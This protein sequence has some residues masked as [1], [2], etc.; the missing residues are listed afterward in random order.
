MKQNKYYILL[1]IFIFS[2][3]CN[4]DFLD[5]PSLDSPSLDNFYNTLEEVQGATAVLYGFPW[6]DFND[7][8][9]HC[10][11]EVLSGNMYTGDPQYAPYMNFTVTANDNRLSEAWNSFFKIVGWSNVIIKA[12]EDKIATGGNAD[13]LNLGIAEAK[14][15]RGVGYFY[16]ARIW[17]DAPLLTDPSEIAQTGEFLIPKAP[18]ADVLRFAA[19]DFM[20]A[21][22]YLG[23]TAPKG[24]VTKYS[25]KGMLAKLYLYQKNYDQARIKAKEV[26]DS[27]K[28]GLFEDYFGMFSASVNNNNKESLFSLQWVI[29]NEWGSQN[30]MQAY[31]APSNLLVT[32]DGWSS[33]MPS[34]DM[35]NAYESGDMRRRWSIME[36]GD[37]Y[38]QWKPT[39]ANNP[40]FNNFMASGYRY[41]VNEPAP[42][43]HRTPTRSSVTKY[44]VGPGGD[45]EP[46][47]AQKTQIGTYILRYADVLLIY[48]E[49]VLG[50]NATT[51]DQSALDAFNAVRQRAQ[52]PAKTELTL[53]DILHERRVEL[54][55]EGDYWF[56]I[57]RQGLAKAQQIIANQ[58]RGNYADNG[59]LVPLQ[60]SL[61]LPGGGLFL[62]IP[63][64]E[65]AQ[66]PKLNEAP[67][68]YY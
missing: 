9:N 68:P 61:N 17:G 33:V 39:R 27:E 21:E 58:E 34:I 16:I 10:I 49:A 38:P 44:V 60:V 45:S 63:L 51:T 54:A 2:V 62:P 32:S 47:L 31:L 57:Q 66:N 59:D 25:A 50:P 12:F 40:D 37:I 20:F 36:H 5:R 42:L 26:I 24:R 23:E 7:K 53:A 22:E 15:I 56:D 4:K 35:L 19:E 8:A 55:F 30:S 48:A 1:L 3:G 11:G 52:L 28:Y 41:D 64:S 29:S 46:V 14:F 65:I 6:F 13:I 67:V 18:Q 43:G